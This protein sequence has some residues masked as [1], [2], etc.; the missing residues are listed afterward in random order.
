MK[1][2]SAITALLFAGCIVVARR[3]E[4]EAPGAPPPQPAPVE[5]YEPPPPPPG[6][7][8]HSTMLKYAKAVPDVFNGFRNV[9]SMRGSQVTEKRTPGSDNWSATA[10]EGM[11]TIRVYLNRHDHKTRTHVQVTLPG[12]SD[13]RLAAKISRDFHADLAREIGETGAP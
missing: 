10:H 7:V 6:A 13:P 8:A 12:G 1:I 3:H 11:T 9:F 5:S 4:G 2:L